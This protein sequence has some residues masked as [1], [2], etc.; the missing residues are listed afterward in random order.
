MN[1]RNCRSCQTLITSE[2]NFCGQCGHPIKLQKAEKNTHTLTII[3][4]FYALLLLFLG[5]NYIYHPKENTLLFQGVAEFV[6]ALVVIGFSAFN[7]KEILPLYS[8]LKSSV[9]PLL[10]TFPVAILTAGIAY[11]ISKILNSFLFETSY[12]YLDG[13]S[14][15]ENPLFY[16]I[17]FIAFLPPIV[18]ELAF[19]GFLF[20]KLRAVTTPVLTILLTAFLFALIHFSIFSMFWI[21]PFGI[22]L[23]FLRYRYNTLWIGMSLHFFHNLFIVLIDYYYYVPPLV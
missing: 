10:T 14:T 20:N 7:Y 5:L 6:F 2:E 17:L 15:Y 13:Y 18:E 22:L 8:N 3:L 12:N 1:K 23:G 21:F 9:V 16:A 19:R 4:S 11:F